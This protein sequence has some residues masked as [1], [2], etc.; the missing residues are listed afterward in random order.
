MK[1]HTTI[2][3]VAAIIFMCVIIPNMK[4]DDTCTPIL[5]LELSPSWFG[6]QIG[7]VLG[8]ETDFNHD[9][10]PDLV[11]E[12]GGNG[13]FSIDIYLNSGAGFDLEPDQSP[14]PSAFRYSNDIIPSDLNTDG[15][16]DLLIFNYD[17]S[18]GTCQCMTML[19]DHGCINHEPSW[20]SP[21]HT[22]YCG[23]IGDITGDGIPDLVMN[24]YLEPM[25]AFRGF[26]DG[27]FDVVPI[28]SSA[29][30]Y[31]ARASTF[32]DINNDNDPDLLVSTAEN[33][34]LVYLNTGGTLDTVPSWQTGYVMN[35]ADIE[36]VDLNRDGYIDAA[37]AGLSSPSA[38][39]INH[40][41][42][43]DDIP[44]WQAG[45]GEDLLDKRYT[46][47]LAWG[48]L[49]GDD[50]PELIMGSRWSAQDGY[51]GDR[52]TVYINSQGIL[53][54]NP[55][56]TSNSVRYMESLIIR[57]FSGDSAKDICG[58]SRNGPEI[59]KNV[60]SDCSEP[61]IDIRMPS[62]L[63]HPGDPFELET[64]I[65]S[66]GQ[67][68]PDTP[69]FVLLDVFGSIFC[70][71][72]FSPVEQ[73]PDHYSLD[74][75]QGLSSLQ[76]IPEFVF[77]EVSGSAFGLC[78]HAFMTNP[79][80]SAIISRMDTV[81]FGYQGNTGAGHPHQESRLE[82]GITWSPDCAREFTAKLRDSKR[83]SFHGGR[84]SQYQ[85]TYGSEPIHSLP[86]TERSGRS[87]PWTVMLYDCSDQPVGDIFNRFAGEFNSGTNLDVLVLRD[88]PEMT[89]QLYYIHEDHTPEMIA[90]WGERS[91]SDY[92]TLRD[93]LLAADSAYPADHYMLTV[94]GHGGAWMG[95][96]GESNP[97]YSLLEIDAMRQAIEESVPIDIL[98]FT[99]P[100]LMGNL[101]AAYELRNLVDIYIASPES[102]NYMVW[103]GIMD[104]IRNMLNDTPDTP[105]I[106]MAE[107]IV[108]WTYE[109]NLG[110]GNYEEYFTMSAVRSDALDSVAI[111]LTALTA[112]MRTR[113]PTGFPFMNDAREQTEMYGIV[114]EDYWQLC[115]VIDFFEEYSLV[116]T[117]PDILL[118]L[119]QTITAL[120]DA[121]IAEWHGSEQEGGHGLTFYFP[122]AGSE[123]LP[124]YAASQLDFVAATAWNEFLTEFQSYAPPTPTP[125]VTPQPPTPAPHIPMETLN[126][127]SGPDIVPDTALTDDFDADGLPD[128][129]VLKDG[130][131]HRIHFNTGAG[132]QSTPGWQA[133]WNYDV[134]LYY[135][136]SG[137]VTGDGYP[138]IVIIHDECDPDTYEPTPTRHALYINR[139]GMPE[140]TPAWYTEPHISTKGAI[141]DI[142][143]DGFNDL[144][145][146]GAQGPHVMYRGKAAGG[147]EDAS[148]WQSSISQ[149]TQ[150]MKLADL[151]GDTYPEFLVL[152][153]GSS[154]YIFRNIGG[155][156]ETQWS[157]KTPVDLTMDA[158]DFDVADSD[159]DGYPEIAVAMSY[160]K[161]SFILGNTGGEIGTQPIW[162]SRV[163]DFSRTIS[164]GDINGDGYPELFTGNHAFY[165]NGTSM[166]SGCN[167]DYIYYNDSGRLCEIPSWV[168]DPLG[169]SNDSGFLDMDGDSDLDLFVGDY[170][171]SPIIYR[172]TTDCDCSGIE[173][174]MPTTMLYPGD[175]FELKALL[176]N[177][178]SS[179]IDARIIVLMDLFGD[180]YCAPSWRNIEDGT[181][182]I[183]LHLP[184]GR[185]EYG[186]IPEFP[187]PDTGTMG[188]GIC[189]YGAIMDAGMT[190]MIGEMD[191]IYFSFR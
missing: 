103:E 189:I 66:P 60:G 76:I 137:D 89:T 145:L 146:A 175:P 96:G 170:S 59:F 55:D 135:P 82:C 141:R 38:V 83:R 46:S 183:P 120:T 180:F 23:A 6:S 97:Q 173:L 112:S 88:T 125:T 62:D 176:C 174:R 128:L 161:P 136:V 157:W 133:E 122:G 58:V 134:H 75:P 159:G 104:D 41:G 191:R 143:G 158:C 68:L 9:G 181:D 150:E 49:N 50:Y 67:A 121:V 152:G 65:S 84:S 72:S 42:G 61:S 29:E 156:L 187:W 63:F 91:M 100:C 167:L 184:P 119:D 73:N 52:I 105:L 126:E 92:T 54:T 186:I 14:C 130:E 102:S 25:R 116:E 138:D 117:D 18:A 80:M 43:F 15:Y 160:D 69:V 77:P 40:S 34:F 64:V 99:A 115:D 179:A 71:P 39:F 31:N 51:G 154:L 165:W 178:E 166:V 7:A 19:N 124:G 111:Q 30:S 47:A 36:C 57:D 87:K 56:W 153:Y 93:L 2:L 22:C 13:I 148:C 53:S 151:D 164:W 26:G 132:F 139:T 190:R 79:E 109:N 188:M 129:L 45:P 94:Y 24:G 78:F 44:V 182:T 101:E 140:T 147:F 110:S 177:R 118:L 32:A 70:A 48:D 168:S 127:W 37:L 107:S 113:L 162:I 106:T 4:A 144:I 21:A 90:D 149:N 28:W 95:V 11:I 10:L 8:A 108:Q 163:R 27:S 131:P 20:I 98:A 17:W 142:N 114:D 1:T 33:P 86:F 16:P 185:S 123:Y 5:P 3:F 169:T 35:A 171:S 172:N 74:I 12:S 85:A 155:S 81:Y